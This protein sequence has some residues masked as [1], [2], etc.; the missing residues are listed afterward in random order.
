MKKKKV[1]IVPL[2]TPQIRAAFISI[3]HRKYRTIRSY[4]IAMIQLVRYRDEDG[5][6]IGFDYE[7]IRDAVLR[8]FPT[9]PCNG[10]HK[11]K[12][13]KM[14]YKEMQ[15][16]ACDLNRRGVKLPF[17]PFRPRHKREV[18]L[19]RRKKKRVGRTL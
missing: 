2:M 6:D 15:E 14:P 18:V 7:Y 1:S 12:P 4:A 11:G 19:D 5:R 13:T 9:V 16:F 10:P 3:Q 17:R 8:K